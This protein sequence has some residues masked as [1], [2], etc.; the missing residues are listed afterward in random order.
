MYVFIRH[1]A[2][3][4]FQGHEGP[5]TKALGKMMVAMCMLMIEVT[6]PKC[7]Y[8]QMLHEYI[9]NSF[10]LSSQKRI[11]EMS[12]VHKTLVASSR[13][14]TFRPSTSSPFSD[15][16]FNLFPMQTILQVHLEIVHTRL[17]TWSVQLS[18]TIK[19]FDPWVI[20]K[21][22]IGRRRLVGPVWP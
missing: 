13:S 10:P 17:R 18:R 16:P 8:V 3:R 6:L 1:E 20:H 5:V 22:C 12:L 14:P 11:Y 15:P 21:F 7:Q 19:A 9:S 2:I 4:Q